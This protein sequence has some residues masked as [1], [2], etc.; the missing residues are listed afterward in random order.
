MS[1]RMKGKNLKPKHF[2]LM[3]EAKVADFKETLVSSS[4]KDSK[5][6][7]NAFHPWL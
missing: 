1:S 2:D 3:L 4:M 6:S 7:S 5:E